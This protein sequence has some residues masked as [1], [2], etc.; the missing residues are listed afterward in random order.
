VVQGVNGTKSRM[1]RHA[2]FA[3]RFDDAQEIFARVSLVQEAQ[4]RII[5][6]FDRADHKEA[7]SI[8]KG[9]Q[10]PLIFEQVFDLDGH[11]V[12]YRWKFPMKRLREFHCVA[13]TLKKSGSPKVMCCAPAVTWRRMSSST[14]SRLTIRN[15]PL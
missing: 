1:K 4:D 3:E 2:K 13:N 15:T 10:V 12:C 8:A 9:R 5:H 11:V 14:T 6:G 7:A